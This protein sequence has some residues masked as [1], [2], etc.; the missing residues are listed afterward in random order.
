[1]PPPQYHDFKL[2]FLI[3][4]H[5]LSDFLSSLGSVQ[6]G[7]ERSP[8]QVQSRTH[9]PS[10]WRRGRKQLTWLLKARIEP[11]GGGGWKNEASRTS[12]V[13]FYQPRRW[14][15]VPNKL[16]IRCF[17]VPVTNFGAS[18]QNVKT[19]Q[20][21]GTPGSALPPHHCPTSHFVLHHLFKSPEI[22]WKME[23]RMSPTAQNPN[24]TPLLCVCCQ[25]EQGFILFHTQNKVFNWLT[26]TEKKHTPHSDN[27]ISNAY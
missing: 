10:I 8:F 27:Y 6:L 1:M 2:L 14:A 17:F 25:E 9:H 16:E 26:V 13:H 11:H 24:P 7:P 3:A 21:Q 4:V 15:L 5:T 18:S 22:L 23:V 12:S 20:K 19:E